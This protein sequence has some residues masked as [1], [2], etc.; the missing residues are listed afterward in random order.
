MT[1]VES[2]QLADQRERQRLN[3]AFARHKFNKI[4]AQ[5]RELSAEQRKEFAAVIEQEGADAAQ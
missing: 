5:F 4:R 1:L 3:D 2:L